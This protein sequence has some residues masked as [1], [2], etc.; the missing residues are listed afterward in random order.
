MGGGVLPVSALIATKDAFHLFNRE[1]L[2]HTS[3]FSGNPLAC[4]AAC[5][6]VNVIRDEDVIGKAQRIGEQLLSAIK[7]LWGMH[8]PIVGDIRGARLLIGIEFQKEHYAADFM[9][10]MM[11]QKVLVSHSLNAH[12]VVRLTPPSTLMSFPAATQRYRDF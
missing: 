10:E 9:L 12:R 4:A 6:A 5:A 8:T 11:S 1:P 3:T 7:Q 2:L